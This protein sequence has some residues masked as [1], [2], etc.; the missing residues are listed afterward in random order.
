MSY[1]ELSVLIPA[2][3]A[4]QRLGQAKQLVRLK[5]RTLIQNSVETAN[6]TTPREIIVVT[7][8]NAKAVQEAVKHPPLRWVHN[9]NWSAGMGG[10]VAA[11]V[12]A[13]DPKS[14][15]VMILL[16]DQWR[17]ET[18]DL[19]LIAET[20]QKNPE[21]I[22]CAQ[23]EGQNMPPVVF[24]SSCFSRLRALEGESGARNLLKEHSD[25]LTPVALENA[26]FDLDTQA[27]LRHMNS[28][29]L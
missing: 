1:P 28:A 4:S 9:S 27:Q 16:S 18:S 2:A 29:N 10:S 13:I 23:A 6:S 5:T 20:W 26:I 17:L 19:R 7:G 14:T 25:M 21:R 11:G 12:K 15:A 24:P 3:G 22:V 8:A